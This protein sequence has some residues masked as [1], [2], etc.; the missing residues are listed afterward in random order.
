[1]AFQARKATHIHGMTIFAG[2]ALV[3]DRINSIIGLVIGIAS[4][5]IAGGMTLRTSCTK[6]TCVEGRFSMTG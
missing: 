4:I 6:E 1:M 3:V 2:C 5:P